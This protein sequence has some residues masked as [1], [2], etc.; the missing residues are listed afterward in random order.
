MTLPWR[1]LFAIVYAV[2]ILGLNP[3]RMEVS[4]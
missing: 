1:F 4:D 3:L 2:V